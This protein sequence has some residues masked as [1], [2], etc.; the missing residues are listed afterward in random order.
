MKKIISVFVISAFFSSYF[1]SAQDTR[2]LKNMIKSL[3]E[4]AGVG[5]QYILL[6][7]IN[8]Y[9][10]WNPLRKPVA[11]AKQLKEVF[12]ENYYVDEIIELY[13]ENA[14]KSGILRTFKGLQDKITSDDSLLIYY[15]G[16]GYMDTEI[17]Q[18]AYWIPS[19]GGLDSYS[20]DN[21][22]PNSSI[23]GMIGAIK[24]M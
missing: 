18:N 5:K 16:H 2:G 21:W 22:L 6:I 4:Y 8:K 19:D 15:A 13:D 23:R 20:Q 24:S 11:D 7:A 9:K 10:E 12:L 17:T 1:L 14:T 3:D